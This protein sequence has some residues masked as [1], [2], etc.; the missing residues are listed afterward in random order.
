MTPEEVE[1]FHAA[2]VA[3]TKKALGL[4][5]AKEAASALSPL[6]PLRKGHIVSLLMSGVLNGRLTDRL[7][8]KCFT[9]RH[10][11][12]TTV[13]EDGKTKKV[14]LDSYVSGIRVIEKGEWYDVI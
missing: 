6:F 7:V 10:Q 13:V 11:T 14:T 9:K 2:T 5:K 1:A 3:N 4:D 8:F 12:E